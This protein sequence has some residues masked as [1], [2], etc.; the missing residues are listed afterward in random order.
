MSDWP[1]CIRAW[2][3]FGWWGWDSQVHFVGSYRQ[4]VSSLEKKPISHKDQHPYSPVLCFSSPTEALSVISAAPVARSRPGGESAVCCRLHSNTI[5]DSHKSHHF[6]DPTYWTS[7]RQCENPIGITSS[8]LIRILVGSQRL[9]L[10][11]NQGSVSMELLCAVILV[12]SEDL[13]K[14]VTDGKAVRPW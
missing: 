1:R 9:W 3:D 12:V 4:S 2:G 6:P 7:F 14:A 10:K 5:S 11:E 8:R 13:V